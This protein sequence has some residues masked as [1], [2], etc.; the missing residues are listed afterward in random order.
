[1]SSANTVR[2]WPRILRLAGVGGALYGGYS[3]YELYI[4]QQ[5]NKIRGAAARSPIPQT[6]VEVLRE[7]CDRLIGY[8]VVVRHTFA[9]SE[10]SF[11]EE[12]TVSDDEASWVR[13]IARRV[14]RLYFT[15]DLDDLAG[16][17]SYDPNEDDPKFRTESVRT[18]RRLHSDRVSNE[19]LRSV[20]G[21]SPDASLSSSTWPPGTHKYASMT[22]EPQRKGPSGLQSMLDSSTEQTLTK[23]MST[24][25]YKAFPDDCTADASSLLSPYL[26]VM[27]GTFA[28]FPFPIPGPLRMCQLGVGGGALP[29]FLQ[30]HLGSVVG[31]L[32]LVDIEPAVLR[33]AVQKM[34]LEKINRVGEMR[35]CAE[36]G[37][38]FLEKVAA[39]SPSRRRDQNAGTIPS[40][41]GFAPYDVLFVDLFVGSR[42]PSFLDNPADAMGFAELCRDA[43]TPQ[44]VVAFNMPYRTPEFEA[45][46]KGVF[47]DK[48]VFALPCSPN[49]NVVYV[50]TRSF[51]DASMATQ[52]KRHVVRRC[53]ELSVRYQ[54]PFDV[55]ASLPL[56]WWVW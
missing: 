12:K 13:R 32:D 49:S 55:S 6:T 17:R 45:V 29:M 35:M 30:Q 2:R 51:G 43:L 20:I 33:A 39:A 7:P 14:Y 3:V 1:M 28:F 37:A 10:P 44:G 48:R 42:L 52:N 15:N 24:N 18:V 25:K 31:Q 34:G 27:L 9:Q 56:S 8:D 21:G 50:A 26:R 53:H 54:L 11:E 5:R 40:N 16:Q 23:C 41:S 22:I 46:C 47:G 4:W 38:A 36:D 19:P